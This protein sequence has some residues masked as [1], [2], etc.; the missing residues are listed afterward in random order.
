M[1]LTF[2]SDGTFDTSAWGG[3]D[4]MINIPRGTFNNLCESLIDVFSREMDE[5]RSK[6]VFI[7]I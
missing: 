5:L 3:T 6:V 2:V 4:T 7:P 1:K